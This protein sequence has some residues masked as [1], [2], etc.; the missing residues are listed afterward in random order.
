MTVN[1]NS[2]GD[3]GTSGLAFIVGALVVVVGLG[4][5]LYFG[6]G[7]GPSGSS[8]TTIERVVPDKPDVNIDATIKKEE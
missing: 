5:F 4:A 6:A 1:N 2:S 8:T 7:D 3:G